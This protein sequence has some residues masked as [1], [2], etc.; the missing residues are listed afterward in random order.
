MHIPDRTTSIEILEKHQGD[1]PERIAHSM[2]VAELAMALGR[3]LVA[4]GHSLDLGLIEAAAILHDILKGQP[5]H[6]HAGG[7]MLRSMGYAQVAAV[8]EVHTRLGGRTPAPEEPI[9]EAEVVYMADKSYRRVNRVTIEE[10]YGIW[11]NTWKDNPTRLESLTR[12]ENRA[13]TVRERIEK[14]MGKT[15]GDI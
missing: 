13:K 9:S 4:Q 7:E 2:A 14:A 11:R 3:E 1:S 10:R 5:A 6:D 8:V 12:G 15:L